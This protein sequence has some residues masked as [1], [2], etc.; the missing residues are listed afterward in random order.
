[1]RQIRKLDLFIK[2]LALSDSCSYTNTVISRGLFSKSNIT[3]AIPTG[4]LNKYLK[5]GK[6]MQLRVN[7]KLIE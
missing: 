4:E 7:T 2:A 6:Q 5:T 1:M 3:K